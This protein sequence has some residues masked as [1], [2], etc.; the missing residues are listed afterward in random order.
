MDLAVFDVDGVLADVEHR[1]HH[2]SG[3]RRDW[4]GFFAAA[5]DDPL[6]A[7]GAALVQQARADGL[8]VVYLSGRPEH[9]RA[10]TTSWLARH[11]LP[12]GELVLRPERDRSPAVAFKLA[13]LR[14]VAT[15]FTID[16]LVDDDEQVVRAVG[17]HD[18]PLVRRVVLAD[19]QT[20]GARRTLRRAQEVDGRT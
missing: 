15:A 1:R 2:V 5:G 10:V 13:R 7:P 19:W 16:L 3:R 17:E 4:A 12:D 9:L 20:G 11:D 18:P 14:E 8:L 6:L